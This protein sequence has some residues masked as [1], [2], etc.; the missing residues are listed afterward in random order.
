M[1]RVEAKHV[2]IV[3][4]YCSVVWL[5]TLI[6]TLDVITTPCPVLLLQDWAMPPLFLPQI[7]VTTFH[8]VCIL[9][10]LQPWRWKQ[11]TSSQCWYPPIKLPHYELFILMSIYSDFQSRNKLYSH[12][13]FNL[14]STSFPHIVWKSV[15]YQF[16]RFKFLAFTWSRPFT[17]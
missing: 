9:T 7:W 6:P 1:C 15:H 17:L 10:L 12:C 3:W 4:L 14:T 8:A 5:P 2:R 13:A 11:H 16:L